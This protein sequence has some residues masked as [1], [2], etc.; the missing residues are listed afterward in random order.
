MIDRIKQIIQHPCP[1]P[2]APS[3]RFEISEAA[4]QHNSNLLA[5]FNFDVSACNRSNGTNICS[6][7]SEF[8]D[9]R[10]LQRL[11]QHHPHWHYKRTVLTNGAEIPLRVPPN[12][13][14]RHAENKAVIAMQNH[15]KAKLHPDLVRKSLENDVRLGFT[16]VLQ[17]DTVDQIKGAVVCPL[18]V[19]EQQRMLN[20]DGTW[21]TKVHLTHDQTFTVLADS[22]SVN[23]LTDCSQ[24]YIRC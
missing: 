24:S 6:P 20:P 13:S 14:S 22:Y 3:F 19:V 23:D 18:G 4:A 5:Q 2:N 8:R 1:T 9:T 17:P 10:I 12:D 21:Q 15:K 7:G 11:L 16:C